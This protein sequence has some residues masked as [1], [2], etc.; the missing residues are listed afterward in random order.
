MAEFF[1]HTIERHGLREDLK[2]IFDLERIAGKISLGVAHPRDLLS[3]KKSLQVLPQIQKQLKTFSAKK[4]KEIHK[5]W[6]NAQDIAGLIEKAIMEEPAFLLTEG[7]IIVA[8]VGSLFFGQTMIKAKKVKGSLKKQ[9]LG[10][11]VFVPL[12]GQFGY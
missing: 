3:L 11:F 7:G 9:N 5:G 6:D 8:P 2:E 10:S 1:S 12:K 4:I